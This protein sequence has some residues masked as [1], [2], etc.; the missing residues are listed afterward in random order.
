[1]QKK[2][3]AVVRESSTP[4]KTVWDARKRGDAFCVDDAG[5]VEVLKGGKK[6]WEVPGVDCGAR[7]G[8]RKVKEGVD[9]ICMRRG[10]VLQACQGLAIGSYIFQFKSA[11]L[12]ALSKISGKSTVVLWDTHSIVK[13]AGQYLIYQTDGNVVIYNDHALALWSSRSAGKQSTDLCLTSKGKV[14]LYNGQ[15]RIE[16]LEPNKTA[17]SITS[18]L[19]TMQTSTWTSTSTSRTSSAT[20]AA[21]TQSLSAFQ[22]QV[23]IL[24]NQFRAKHNISALVYNATVE[25]YA[26]SHANTLADDHCTLQIG[27]RAN[28]TLGQNLAYY[29]NSAPFTTHFEMYTD[30][31]EKSA[32]DPPSVDNTT[33]TQMLWRGTSAV[34]CAVARGTVGGD[35]CEVAV[36]DYWP[37]GNIAQRT[38]WEG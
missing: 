15:T 28:D 32:I 18:S 22:E 2:G 9:A 4:R 1:M 30:L 27:D 25:S 24:H 13:S 17:S 31:W 37:A 12:M 20:A 8:V 21:P 19:S 35:L 7:I 38:W 10:A 14:I 11:G 36:C 34:G 3:L 6:V 23:L 16:L 33:A 29:R 26:L 5:G